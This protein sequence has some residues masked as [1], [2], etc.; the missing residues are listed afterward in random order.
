MP[1]GMRFINLTHQNITARLWF[2]RYL[3]QVRPSNR[4]STLH[5]EPTGVIHVI[6]VLT[7]RGKDMITANAEVTQDSQATG[8]QPKAPKKARAGAE[9]AH[10]A[11]TKKKSGRKGHPCQESAQKR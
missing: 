11:P 3:N 5:F 9:S 1:P 4:I 7:A 8:E 6:A 2:F 10:I